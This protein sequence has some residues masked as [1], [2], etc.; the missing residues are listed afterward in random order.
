MIR[1]RFILD[2]FAEH[3]SK[4]PF[5]LFDLH[6]QLLR[7][8]MFEAYNQWLFETVQNLPGYQQWIRNHAA[9]NDAFTRFQ[10]GRVYKTPPDQYYRY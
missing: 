10:R 3:A 7:E 4:M 8:G 2:W 9:E 5:R 1:T 6:Q